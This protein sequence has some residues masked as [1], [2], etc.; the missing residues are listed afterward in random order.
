MSEFKSV[1]NCFRVGLAVL[2]FAATFL[3]AP[4]ARADWQGDLKMSGDGASQA[5]MSGN[6]KIFAKGTK[7]R[8]EMSTAGHA[9]TVIADTANN[10]GFVL[11]DAQH[12][13]M[14]MSAQMAS[15]QVA[16][17]ST[18]DVEGCFKRK[19]YKVTGKETYGGHPCVIYEGTEKSGK[20]TVA[21][22]IWRPTD[23]KEVFMLK[24]VSKADNGKEVIAELSGVK[25]SKLQDS[26]FKVP[27]GYKMM[28]MPSFH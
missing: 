9:L 8:L 22:K 7:L 17:C 23:L 13:A 28:S 10:K 20:T 24:M 5:A 4:V 3:T 12:L 27:T 25:T 21:Q 2:A 19:G 14:E 18:K 16:L 6:G 1:I 26:I 11:M 15:G